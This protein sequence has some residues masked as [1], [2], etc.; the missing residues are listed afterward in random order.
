M[1]N[2]NLF[3]P[4]DEKY[5]LLAD[6]VNTYHYHHKPPHEKMSL[7]DYNISNIMAGY[8]DI[9]N[10]LIYMF[11]YKNSG[12]ELLDSKD[13]REIDNIHKL[14]DGFDVYVNFIG[15]KEWIANGISRVN[16]H[17]IINMNK[18]INFNINL[19]FRQKFTNFLDIRK[20]NPLS[21]EENIKSQIEHFRNMHLE[22]KNYNITTNE[23]MMLYL[24]RIINENITLLEKL[25]YEKILEIIYKIYIPYIYILFDIAHDFKLRI[26]LCLLH[27][28][29]FTR[30]KICVLIDDDY[31]TANRSIFNIS[32]HNDIYNDKFKSYDPF[33]LVNCYFDGKEILISRTEDLPCKNRPI[34]DIIHEILIQTGDLPYMNKIFKKNITKK[35][36][37]VANVNV[38]YNK[39]KYK[40]LIC[41]S[42][43]FQDNEYDYSSALQA[44]ININLKNKD[45]DLHFIYNRVINGIS[46]NEVKYP[47]DRT[48]KLLQEFYKGIR[49]ESDFLIFT[50]TRTDNILYKCD[51][52]FNARKSSNAFLI[53]SDLIKYIINS[54]NYNVD[55]AGSGI[56]HE[57]FISI[58][59]QYVIRIN[60][61]F[62]GDPVESKPNTF[63]NDL[64][65]IFKKIKRVA[66][67]RKEY[68]IS[69]FNEILNLSRRYFALQ[70]PNFHNKIMNMLDSIE[71]D[72][73]NYLSVY[74]KFVSD[75]KTLPDNKIFYKDLMH[76]IHRYYDFVVIINL[77]IYSNKNIIIIGNKLHVINILHLLLY[78][79]YEINIEK[80]EDEKIL[81][82]CVSDMNEKEFIFFE[83]SLVKQSTV[84]EMV[85]DELKKNINDFEI[86]V[87]TFDIIHV[88]NADDKLCIIL[89]NIFKKQINIINKSGGK[90]DV[91][92]ILIVI[93]VLII[94]ILIIIIFNI[95]KQNYTRDF[96]DY[97]SSG[98]L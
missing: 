66:V 98:H 60:Q 12:S 16:Q 18:D 9:N 4:E 82:E 43:E 10:S 19:N 49:N 58:V 88:K 2:S 78:N 65:E 28:V 41:G 79:K 34:V 38:I 84:S 83:E 97:G 27:F 73:E 7:Q 94:I 72:I 93:I 67:D 32:F 87:E 96:S 13:C 61:L 22:M 86:Y 46:T 77:L 39:R 48:E 29:A 20:K 54:F 51:P 23:Y 55:I 30:K 69:E 74:N 15:D 80:Y 35:L 85:G 89:D 25:K 76:V 57:E 33:K 36:A 75:N 62:I 47:D 81:K 63:V 6:Y 40:Y 68:Y 5:I 42:D 91:N 1:L 59:H 92:M 70:N 26:F 3:Y 8:T 21:R 44:M 95:F 52:Y 71:T 14:I 17:T 50:E 64:L 24:M 37:L 45:K 53:R 31:Y 11:R 56:S 90:K